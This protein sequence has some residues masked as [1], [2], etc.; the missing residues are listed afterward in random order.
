MGSYGER[1][2]VGT[3]SQTP[4]CNVSMARLRALGLLPEDG[5]ATDVP[6][7]LMFMLSFEIDGNV[8]P[9]QQ[10]VVL[11]K[12]PAACD[13]YCTNWPAMR[14]LTRAGNPVGMSRF[15]PSDGTTLEAA[16]EDDNGCPKHSG[17]VVFQLS[18]QNSGCHTGPAG[19]VASEEGEQGHVPAGIRGKARGRRGSQATGRAAATEQPQVASPARHQVS[20]PEL[21]QLSVSLLFGDVACRL[22]MCLPIPSACIR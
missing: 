1:M 7:S 15:L 14:P 3:T 6:D 20:C 21:V 16:W 10:A 19:Q 17:L 22:D 18:T 4:W 8:L 13:Y 9:F 11:R 5:S 2:S 12:R